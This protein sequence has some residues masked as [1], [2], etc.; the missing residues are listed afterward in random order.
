[1]C[2]FFYDFAPKFIGKE[3]EEVLPEPTNIWITGGGV[4]MEITNF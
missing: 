1:M 3:K 2:F 4:K